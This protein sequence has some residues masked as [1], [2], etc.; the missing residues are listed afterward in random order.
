MK[1]LRSIV[2][3]CLLSACA[4][5]TAPSPDSALPDAVARQDSQAMPAPDSPSPDTGVTSD[6]VAIVDGVGDESLPHI[7]SSLNTVC[8][9]PRSGRPWC[10]GALQSAERVERGPAPWD[11]DLSGAPADV[12]AA[13]GAALCFG[14]ARDMSLRCLG[15]NRSGLLAV[16]SSDDALFFP[17]ARVVHLAGPLL[18]LDGAGATFC[19]IVPG[20]LQCWGDS[21]FGGTPSNVPQP[22]AIRGVIRQLS[23]GAG[24]LCVAEDGGAV[25]CAGANTY[26]GLGQD[27]GSATTLSSLTRVPGLPNIREVSVGVGTTCAVAVDRSV[28]CWGDNSRR[29][30]GRRDVTLDFRP[31]AIPLLGEVRSIDVGAVACIVKLDGSV[32]C[33]GPRH[34]G[35]IGDGVWVRPTSE[36]LQDEANYAF[37]PERVPSVEGAV[38]ITVGAQVACALTREDQLWCWGGRSPLFDPRRNSSQHP[39]L[40]G[41]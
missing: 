21:P 27:P 2:Q 36:T 13:A 3:S 14:S 33:W 38:A 7:A 39:Y 12:V 34:G 15:L 17:E 6:A 25:H 28:W 26:G 35:L 40:V 24:A 29:L 37:I 18:L 9:V 4:A 32:W 8:V 22:V 20:Q 11:V 41:R 19:A 1:L 30:L 16:G 31:R 5:T 10:F 23:V